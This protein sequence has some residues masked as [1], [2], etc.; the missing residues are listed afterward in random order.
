MKSQVNLLVALIQ[1]LCDDLGYDPSRDIVTICQRY[2]KEGISFLTVTLPTLDD[3]LLEGLSSGRLPVIRG[4]RTRGRLPLFLNGLWASIADIEGYLLTDHAIGH[5][6]RVIRQIVLFNKK[7]K[8][9]CSDD[10][11]DLAINS[12]VETDK[13]LAFVQ[14]PK[15]SLPDLPDIMYKMFAKSIH[16]MYNSGVSLRYGHGPGSVA[17][18]YD[19]V[20]KWDFPILPDSIV[21]RFGLQAFHPTYSRADS[22]HGRVPARLIAVP[23]TMSKPR[24]ISVEPAYNQFIQQGMQK[25]LKDNFARRGVICNYSD[26]TPNQRLAKIG[27]ESG[28][29]FTLDLS[30]ASDRISL[31]LFLWAFSKFPSFVKDVLACRSEFI[32][33]PDGNIRLLNKFASMGSSMTFPVQC[34][35]FTGLLYIAANKVNRNLKINDLLYDRER[36]SVYG[37]DIIAPTAVYPSLLEIMSISGLKVNTKKTFHKGSFRESCGAD[38]YKGVNVT[39]YYLRYSLDSKLK[40][41]DLPSLIETANRISQYGEGRASKFIRLIVAKQHPK[42]KNLEIPEDENH[43]SKGWYST[44]PNSRWNKHLQRIEY[45]MML[46]RENDPTHNT[47]DYLDSSLLHFYL[48]RI[49][50]SGPSGGDSVVGYGR[51]DSFKTIIR[52]SGL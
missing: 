7:Y 44:S 36:Y 16:S 46:L 29:L 39:P 33:L 12:F 52:W 50:G 14:D 41:T 47:C 19:K 48:A 31:K 25:H 18:S 21:D 51:P 43:I 20:E 5:Y 11:V 17:E 32:Q 49:K 9:V 6:V 4:W 3:F 40:P 26:Q 42:T 28:D 2:S 1:D 23:K 30:E 22:V 35:I 10:K 8:E 45:R 37:D 15:L 34:M 24:L 27:S 38:W 13:E